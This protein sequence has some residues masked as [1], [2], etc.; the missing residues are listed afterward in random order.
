M[1]CAS[2]QTFFSMLSFYNSSLKRKAYQYYAYATTSQAYTPQGPAKFG[3][4]AAPPRTAGFKP[5]MPG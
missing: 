5:V 4:F 2:T 1:V 3:P